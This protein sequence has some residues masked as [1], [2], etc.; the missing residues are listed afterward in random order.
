MKKMGITYLTPPQPSPLKSSKIEGMEHTYRSTRYRLLPRTRAKHQRLMQV[1]GA[2]VW[3]WNR[4]LAHSEQEH[5]FHERLPWLVGKPSTT[6]FSLGKEFTRLRAKTDWLRQLPFAAVR[7]TLKHQAEAWRKFFKGQG[8]RPRFKSKYRERTVTFPEPGHFQIQ[9]GSLRLQK[10]G[11]FRLAR[12][13]GDPY[14][15]CEARSVTVKREC[16]KWYAVVLYRV[17]A[18]VVERADDGRAVG[19]DMNVGQVACS[20]GEIM[21]MDGARMGRLEARRRRYQR[22][23]ARQVKGSNR[24]N[25]TKR[26]LAKVCR[27]IRC[28]RDN[29]QHHASKRIAGKAGTVAVESLGTKGMTASAK[30]DADNPGRRVR[31]KAGLNRSIL[32]T[33]W[34][35]LKA[36]LE[37][38]SARLIEVNPKHTSQR[39][40]KCG[41]TDKG[42]RTTQA[43]FEC[44]ACG[45]RDNADVNAALNILA[46]GTGATGRGGGEVTRPV[47]RQDIAGHHLVESCI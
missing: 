26:R 19:V 17:P 32:N 38:K 4:M 35:G 30:G 40:A 24:R 10:L 42:N 20:D 43:S 23:M 37:Y 29:W 8:G 25:V 2:C 22:R 6:F 34:H 45:H 9:G 11:W 18:H 1:T 13:G 39:C 5:M 3:T 27:N 46:L 44:L 36:K 41:F 7:H 47:K 16:G 14:G 21:R 12:R 28:H 15:Q 31:Q 33:G